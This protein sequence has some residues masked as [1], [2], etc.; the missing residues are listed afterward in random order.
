V[1]I[2]LGLEC[3]IIRSERS[4]DRSCSVGIVYLTSLICQCWSS[5]L[6]RAGSSRELC[7]REGVEERVVE[8]RELW[9]FELCHIRTQLIESPAEDRT[10]CTER[11]GSSAG[12][13]CKR[14]LVEEACTFV[15]VKQRCAIEDAAGQVASVHAGKGV[16]RKSVSQLT[17][18][19][20]GSESKDSTYRW[21]QYYRQCGRYPDTQRCSPPNLPKPL[22][23][24]LHCQW[25]LQ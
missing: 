2:H 16:Y 12:H 9:T 21:C 20:T 3:V 22:V 17:P 7:S 13:G 19:H 18:R 23:L 24:T 10:K 25:L 1:T 15:A 11:R 8:G 14:S 5:L 4:F 6:E